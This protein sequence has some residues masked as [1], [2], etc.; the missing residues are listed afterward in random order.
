MSLEFAFSLKSMYN[1]WTILIIERKN[2]FVHCHTFLNRAYAPPLF[3]T[4]IT[5]TS[6]SV[7]QYSTV[8]STS[9]FFLSGGKKGKRELK[10]YLLCKYFQFSS[11]KRKRKHCI[12]PFLKFITPVHF[13]ALQHYSLKHSKL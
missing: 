8:H 10:V 1:P 2:A 6:T 4:N 9:I 13:V 5:N 11:K 3:A 7:W 12:T